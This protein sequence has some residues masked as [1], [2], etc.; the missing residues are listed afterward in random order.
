MY[1]YTH[2]TLNQFKTGFFFIFYFDLAMS[3]DVLDSAITKKFG[4]AR[5]KT[6]VP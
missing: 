5:T 3:C 2:K 6:T 1:A 4:Y